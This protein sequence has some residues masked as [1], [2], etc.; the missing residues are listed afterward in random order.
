MPECRLVTPKAEPVTKL[1][2]NAITNCQIHPRLAGSF[3]TAFGK[4]Q[5]EVNTIAYGETP[6]TDL[7]CIYVPYQFDAD[8]DRAKRGVRIGRYSPKH[9]DIQAYIEVKF[10][11]FKMKTK[12]AQRAFLEKPLIDVLVRIQAATK[13]KVTHQIPEVIRAVQ[14]LKG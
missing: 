4:F 13:G 7:G 9:N 12:Q 8:W 14:G 10:Q 3:D 1:M 2:I 11:D 6:A 5:K